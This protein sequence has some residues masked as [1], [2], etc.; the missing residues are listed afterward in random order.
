[1]MTTGLLLAWIQNWQSTI[2]TTRKRS[3]RRLCFYTCLSVILFTGGLSASV[4]T[5][6]HPPA[7]TPLP[8][9]RPS[10]G[11][12]TTSPSP[13]PGSRTPLQSACWEIQV[14]SGRYASYWNAYFCSILFTKATTFTP[15]F[16]LWLVMI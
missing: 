8:R 11:A 7:D 1:M 9:S 3:L 2:F 10:P 4:H 12:D 15:V 14:T 5:G 13:F 16:R 6:I